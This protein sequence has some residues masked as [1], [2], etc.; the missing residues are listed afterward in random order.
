MVGSRLLSFLNLKQA[1][2]TF[3]Q[4]NSFVMHILSIFTLEQNEQVLTLSYSSD[5]F[6]NVWVD[7]FFSPKYT[8]IVD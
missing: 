5:V 3:L 6:F 7:F 4:N 2:F 8:N 1:S